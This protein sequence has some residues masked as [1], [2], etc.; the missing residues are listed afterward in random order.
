MWRWPC[1]SCP[2][3]PVQ[4][5]WSHGGCWPWRHWPRRSWPGSCPP[6]APSESS[7]SLA[8]G[9]TCAALLLF[10]VFSVPGLQA[11]NPLLA[12][13]P[14]E[15]IE[16]D[17]DRVVANLPKAGTGRIYTRFEWGEYFTWA[18]SPGFKVFM[19]GRIEIFPDKV[20]QEYEAVTTG[21]DWARIL[22]GYNV[23][24]LVLDSAYPAQAK[25]LAEVEKSPVWEQVL[26]ARTAWLYCRRR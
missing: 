7:P 6:P 10:A 19:D 4:C 13:R 2:S 1:A 12:F 22:D 11:Y 21:R 14:K 15:R 5:A 9:L 8:A 20:W 23:D 26:Q 25:L 24:V 18:A 17:L 3:P 16:H